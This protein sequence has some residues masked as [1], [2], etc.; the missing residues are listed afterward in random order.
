MIH[1]RRNYRLGH[2]AFPLCT[3]VA[4]AVHAQQLQSFD[5]QTSVSDITAHHIRH[6]RSQRSLGVQHPGSGIKMVFGVVGEVCR[7][8]DEPIK[9]PE[10]GKTRKLL[11]CTQIP[12]EQTCDT[13]VPRRKVS[14]GVLS[15]PILCMYDTSR[16][17]DD[18]SVRP[19]LCLICDGTA[20]FYATAF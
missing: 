10:T 18:L 4:P 14:S 16:R 20:D 11:Y 12:S 9:C 7:D 13:A 2:A 1:P 15:E 5:P 6:R 19:L 17:L 3:Y 8:G